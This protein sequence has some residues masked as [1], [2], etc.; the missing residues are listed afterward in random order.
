MLYLLDRFPYFDRLAGKRWFQR[1]VVRPIPKHIQNLCG[2][3]HG[4]LFKGFILTTFDFEPPF[5]QSPFLEG[6]QQTNIKSLEFMFNVLIK[7]VAKRQ[8]TIAKGYTKT[9]LY[10][11]GSSIWLLLDE[12]NNVG[13]LYNAVYYVGYS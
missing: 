3:F 8:V 6:W 2:G 4:S 13:V 7:T 10:G 1:F 12:T 5:E 9:V 11:S